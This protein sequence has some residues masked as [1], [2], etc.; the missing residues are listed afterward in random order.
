MYMDISKMEGTRCSE[1]SAIK[2]HTPGNN[3]KV[4]TQHLEHAESL[5][6]DKTKFIS[7]ASSSTPGLNNFPIQWNPEPLQGQ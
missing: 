1:T 7:K 2:H 3:P 5:N 6:Q 4:Y